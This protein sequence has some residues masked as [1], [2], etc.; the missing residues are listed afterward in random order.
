M[1]QTGAEG[2][3][4]RATMRGIGERVWAWLAARPYENVGT[5]G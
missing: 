1:T 5:R 2:D 3:E 4:V